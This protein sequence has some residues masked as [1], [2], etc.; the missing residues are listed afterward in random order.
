M[1]PVP[2]NHKGNN[3]W[4]EIKR[5]TKVPIAAQLQSCESHRRTWCGAGTAGGPTT[6]TKA[7]DVLWTAARYH[8]HCS[9]PQW[10]W[11]LSLG[12][13]AVL[14][15]A[16]RSRRGAGVPSPAPGQWGTGLALQRGTACTFGMERRW[17]KPLMR[18]QSG[19]AVYKRWDLA[20]EVL[21]LS[22]Q[23]YQMSAQKGHVSQ[24][25]KAWTAWL[26]R[27]EQNHY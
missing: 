6:D 22:Q 20:R 24:C 8:C 4:K 2:W 18:Y 9:C 27:N 10:G 25:W 13:P 1:L 5:C 12:W 7:E 16:P 17:V 26:A 3:P 15:P 23:M 21:E 14:S 11:R 19:W